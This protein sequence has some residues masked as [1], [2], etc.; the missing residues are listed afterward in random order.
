[1][2]GCSRAAESKAPLAGTFCRR[3]ARV[4]LTTGPD[5]ARATLI[6]TLRSC[7]C[8]SACI[9]AEE[10]AGCDGGDGALQYVVQT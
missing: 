8:V 3:G 9:Q 1:M 5:A 4:A 2:S 7:A 10:A 6:I